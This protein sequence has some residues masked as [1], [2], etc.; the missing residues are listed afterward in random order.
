LLAQ[1]KSPEEVWAITFTK[2]A[3]NEMRERVL[4]A[5]LFAAH[6]AEPES[7][8]KRKT[9]QLA[10]AVLQQ[11]EKYQWQLLINPNQLQIK[12]IDSLCSYL[13]IQLPLLAQ[14]GSQ[15]SIAESPA[16]LYEEAAHQVLLQIESDEV[17]SEA[18]AA[19]LL[20]LDNDLNQ[21]KSLLV[22]LLAKRDQWMSYVFNH[23][24]EFAITDL[25]EEYMT[26]VHADADGTV[27]ALFPAELL[28]EALALNVY[29]SSNLKTLDPVSLKTQQIAA[30]LLTKEFAWRK[31]VD[32]RN[33]FPAA[34]S[35]KNTEEKKLFSEHKDRVKV[36]LEELQQHED[37]RLALENILR[38][39]ASGIQKSESAILEYLLPVLKL[40]A[41]QLRVTFQ[42][43]GQ[44][45]FIENAQAALTALG[46][47]DAPTNLALA[48]DYKIQHI[49][50]DEFQDTSSSQYELLRRLTNG[51]QTG[52]GR[53]LF[54]VGD[55]MQS[56][57]RFREAEVGL[58]LRMRLYGIGD[59]KLTPLTL[60]LN[61]RSTPDIVNWNNRHFTEIFPQ[62]TNPASGAVSYSPS[63][64]KTPDSAPETARND[65]IE[66]KAF[67]TDAINQGSYVVE[68][69]KQLQALH[70]ADNI[71]IL[72]RSRSH[73]KAIIPIIREQGIPYQAIEIDPLATR[74]TIQDLLSLT[75]ALLHLAD[76]IAWL[77]ILR[78]PWG[79]LSL[80]DL[81]TITS[82]DKH[83]IIWQQ[84]QSVTV[85]NALSAQGQTA[86][87]RI[88]PA[89][90]RALQQR[91]RKTLR[92]WIESTWFA[93]GG[94]ACLTDRV[95][96]DDV[97]T[98]FDTLTKLDDE[99]THFSIEQLKEK[100]TKAYAVAEKNAKLQIMT[101]HAAKGLEFDSVILPQIE[102]SLPSDDKSLLIW[103]EH[104]LSSKENVLLLAPVKATDEKL[105]STY[106]YIRWQQ[107]IK[108]HYETDRLFYV[109]TTRAKKR[110]FMYYDLKNRVASDSFLSKLEPFIGKITTD[111][112]SVETSTSSLPIQSLKRLPAS[113]SNPLQLKISAPPAKHNT[114]TG[115]LLV[116]DLPR[117]IGVVIH[118]IL[119]QI[120]N[121]SV[122]WWEQLSAQQRSTLIS[123]LLNR[124][125]TVL[126][127]QCGA[128]DMVLRAIDNTISDPHGRW[129]LQPH[130]DAQAEFAITTQTKKGYSNLIIDRTFLDEEGVRWIVDYKTSQPL[131]GQLLEE[132]IQ[133][134]KDSYSKQLMAY[135][136]AMQSFSSNGIRVGLY[137]PL[138]KAWVE[139]N[140]Q[141]PQQTL[142]DKRI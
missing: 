17:W 90:Q 78:A 74:Q 138:V 54:V 75:A 37:L 47:D 100:I 117:K 122:A 118:A 88:L 13:T 77:A 84:L 71:A 15:P 107:S 86:V 28:N 21:L 72:V 94:P 104:T 85:I 79:G 87:K 61:F 55:P 97:Q 135:A 101:I 130:T 140:V 11:D 65:N 4:D 82:C 113:W 139:V 142:Q 41:A 59:I 58:F 32:A 63:V 132:F 45:D 105:N 24:G 2:K 111:E 23:N 36:L 83:E 44:I 114:F 12:T 20:H 27:K 121:R 119:Q 116:S 50:V 49:L 66:I 62:H 19:L 128:H 29:A 95:D 3:A 60:S 48:L 30:M 125:I 70:S 9:W 56:I 127:D 120:A 14:F 16:Y 93:L 126:S 92:E 33:G 131:E 96:L 7:P 106:N 137:F 25:L 5:I 141:A 8:H 26:K 22:A 80:A 109:A 103:M 57:Y 98:F 34:S 76:R 136:E 124:E 39:P 42:Q 134:E 46:N 129:I 112:K 99:N 67:G 91:G 64:V 18:I 133:H 123:N 38:L 108:A 31:T 81:L 10:K 89:L 115:F 102:K 73:L 68:K 69:I 1:V 53:T 6:H 110:L 52:D 43:Y 40:S 35:T 51:W